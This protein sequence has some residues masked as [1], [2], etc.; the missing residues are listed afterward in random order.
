[1]HDEW[2]VAGQRLVAVFLRV[3]GVVGALL[4]REV[5]DVVAGPLPFRLVPPDQLLPLAPRLA[6]RG[7]GA[8]VIEDAPVARPGVA[9]AVA[10]A[11]PRLARVRF[12][13]A[14]EDAGVDP[15]A[16]GG[17]AVI[18]QFTEVLDVVAV[19]LAED[20]FH[21]FVLVIPCQRAEAGV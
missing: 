3:A 20:L 5:G 8:A 9:P 11:A 16:A 13:L 12:V 14:V 1:M 4:F 2:R 6:I 7:G 10:V 21:L 18:F 15:A 19:N 17:G